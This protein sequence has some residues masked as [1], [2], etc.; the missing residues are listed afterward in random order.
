MP[1]ERET[2]QDRRWRSNGR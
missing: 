2:L 1:D